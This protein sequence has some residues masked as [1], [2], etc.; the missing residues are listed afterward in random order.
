LCA[1]WQRYVPF[2]AGTYRFTVFADDGV[3]LWADDRLLSDQWQHP[4]VAT[5]SADIALT[6]GYHRV[7]SEYYEGG[8]SAGVRLSWAAVR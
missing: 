6:Q 8:G 4:Q 1:R 3:R 2:H 5:F 7:R